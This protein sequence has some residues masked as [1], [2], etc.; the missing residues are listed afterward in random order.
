[1][2]CNLLGCIFAKKLNTI[3]TSL[4]TGS[5]PPKKSY[6]TFPEKYFLVFII[7]KLNFSFPNPVYNL[8][9]PSGVQL[10]LKLRTPMVFFFLYSWWLNMRWILLCFFVVQPSGRFVARAE[11]PETQLGW[12]LSSITFKDPCREVTQLFYEETDASFHV[13][14]PYLCELFF[15]WNYLALLNLF[16]IN[17]CFSN[18]GS[19]KQG[20]QLVIIPFLDSTVLG[21][22][23]DSNRTVLGMKWTI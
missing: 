6:S 18:Y 1:M 4:V 13:W 15:Q 11:A 19:S 12:H 10:V 21:M 23:Q 7:R 5:P 22:K 8:Y 16:V 2:C 14:N 20:F 3:Y 9:I 17:L